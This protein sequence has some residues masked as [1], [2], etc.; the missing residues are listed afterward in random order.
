MKKMVNTSKSLS[1][2]DKIM[3]QENIQKTFKVT[4]P[5]Q[6]KVVNIRGTIS[7]KQGAGSQIEVKAIK[8]IDCPYADDTIIEI[9]QAEDGAVN[10]ITRF[11]RCG[12][13]SLGRPCKVEYEISTPKNTS[14]RINTV[15]G[16]VRVADVDG[17]HL[18]TSVSGEVEIDN[19]SGEN[20]IKTV[21][22][23][24]VG[25][26]INGPVRYKTVSGSIRIEESSHPTIKSSTISGQVIIH[27]DVGDGPY[28]FTSVSGSSKL[29]VPDDTQCSVKAQ[30][31]SGRF[32]TDLKVLS[33]SIRPRS[34]ELDIAG[35]G[36]EIFMKSV[37]GNL[38]ILTSENVKGEVPATTHKSHQQRIDTLRKFE[39]G[40]LT[41][42]ETLAEL[43]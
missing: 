21:S 29:I 39:S 43:N 11:I 37:S 40:E 33:K 32:R 13:V 14:A 23:K 1:N 34:W 22:G 42:E 15:S 5:A 4:E 41:I 38:S 18:I 36:T 9:W 31:L 26:R 7:L 12:I 24:I 17:D 20:A 35:G 25:N 6:L 30:S 3:A 27:S 16:S 19:V 10:V 28:Q 2:E 8:H